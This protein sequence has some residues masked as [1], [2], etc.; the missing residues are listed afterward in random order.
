MVQSA[1][2][3]CA[4]LACDRVCAYKRKFR[5]KVGTTRVSRMEVQRTTGCG[6]SSSSSG[7]ATASAFF[8][9]LPGRPRGLPCALLCPLPLGSSSSSSSGSICVHT[10]PVSSQALSRILAIRQTLPLPVL[11]FS[12]VKP[13]FWHASVSLALAV[14]PRWPV[15]HVRPGAVASAPPRAYT[16]QCQRSVTVGPSLL[17]K[18]K[19]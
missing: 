4:C 18:V 1:L 7:R 16:Q 11:L 2:V 3:C 6:A 10:T 19:L 17:E 5:H 12:L 15:L 13:P 8:C 14:H 9:G